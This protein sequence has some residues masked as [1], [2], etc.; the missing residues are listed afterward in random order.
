MSNSL[1]SKTTAEL[2]AMVANAEAILA[3][4]NAKL[5]AKAT[6]FRDAAKLALDARRVIP[7]GARAA[8]DPVL[9]AATKRILEVAAEAQ[10]R[11]D[12]SSETAKARGV[13]QPHAL[14]SKDGG[15]KTGGGVRTKKY[16][17]CP[18][19][20]Y[21]GPAGIGMLQYAVPADGAEG[22]WTGGLVAVGAPELDTPMSEEEAVAAFLKALAETA[23]ARP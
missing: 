10:A 20:S 12:L 13:K 18:Y 6:E 19:I 23:P 9:E 2:K 1:D 3:G 15:P 4:P 14:L 5:H 16:R 22:F 8:V 17:R 7:V 11:F 21:R